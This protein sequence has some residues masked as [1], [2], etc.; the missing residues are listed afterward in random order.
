M[1]YNNVQLI[2]TQTIKEFSFVDDNLSEKQISAAIDLVQDIHLT[3]ALGLELMDRIKREVFENNVS[4]D[5][6]TLIEEHIQKV[7]IFGVLAE[8]Q[9]PLAYKIR[10]I[11]VTQA[12]DANVAPIGIKDI[13]LNVNH[14]KNIMFSYIDAMKM[15]ICNNASK[16]PE[17][18]NNA[19][20]N[21]K[22]DNNFNSP[23]VL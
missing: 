14:Y 3:G 1:S 9:V 13:E 18:F 15:Y 6:K 12:S 4:D 10:N 7:L 11:G 8:L 2:S 16:F 17:L 21:R 20:N 23:I 5:V 19:H 22:S